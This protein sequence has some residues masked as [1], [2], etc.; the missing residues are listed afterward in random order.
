MSPP[1]VRI[2]PSLRAAGI[3]LA[4][5]VSCEIGLWML[6]INQRDV[7]LIWPAAGISAGIMVRWGWRTLP[8][9]ALGH[10]VIWRSLGFGPVTGLVP[11]LYP[12]EAGLAYYL[13]YRIPLLGKP[14]RSAMN[15]STWRL[16]AVPW[17]AAIPCAILIGWAGI[18]TARFATGNGAMIM[19]KIA[20]AHVHGMVAF[21]PLVIHALKGDFRFPAKAFSTAGT[22]AAVMAL[23][24]MVLAFMGFFRETLGMS[25]AAYLPFPLVIMA[26]IS[27]RPPAISCFLAL[28]CAGSAIL[29]GAGQGPFGDGTATGNPLELGIYNLIICSV[30][31]T[32]SVGSSRYLR[33][34]RRTEQA[35]EAA[36]VELWEW[37]LPQGFHSISGDSSNEHLIKGAAGHPPLEALGWITASPSGHLRSIDNR[38]KQRLERALPDAELLIS[39]GRILDRGRDGTPLEAIGILQ[40]LSAIRRAEEALIALGHQRAQLKSLQSRLNPH[41]LFNALNAIRAMI[42][43]NPRRASDAITT[44]SKLLRSNLVNSDRPLIPF[45]DE[46]DTVHQLLSI[47][48]MRFEDR[49]RTDIVVNHETA[50]ILVPPMIVFNLVEN[51]LVHGIERQPGA[52][53]LRLEANTSGEILVVTV[54]NPGRLMEPLKQGIG[55]GDIRQRI[56]LIFGAAGKFSL[57]QSSPDVVS[58]KITLPASSHELAHC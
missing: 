45:S 48:T 46:M 41:F 29:T 6:R 56:E 57:S 30:A 33:Q 22:F 24:V 18:A 12:L 53:T 2:Q 28:W 19:A 14:D 35:L 3:A 25:S 49:L 31:Y 58:A 44:L 20:T 8:W 37:S 47:A 7:G 50:A 15:H 1:P 4:I 9:I 40:D 10:T 21:G 5:A 32:L 42:H 55:I 43:L 52:G 16:M 11:L 36:G 34:L 23:T 54:S 27:L 38:W 17:L 13:G 51:A 26:G 39:S